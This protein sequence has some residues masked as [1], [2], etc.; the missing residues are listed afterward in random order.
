MDARNNERD[1]PMEMQRA[2]GISGRDA[3]DVMVAME[4]QVADASR[5]R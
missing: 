1:A 3:S 5:M 4:I 2:G